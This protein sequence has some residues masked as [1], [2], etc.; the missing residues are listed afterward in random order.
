ML[1]FTPF[2]APGSPAVWQG[3]TVRILQWNADGTMLIAGQ[4]ITRRVEP[5]ELAPAEP[6]ALDG[7]IEDRRVVSR[8]R[9][10][11]SVDTLFDAYRAWTEDSGVS[12]FLIYSRHTF[13]AALQRRGFR[14]TQRH[15]GLFHR[16]RQTGFAVALDG[17]QS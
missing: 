3:N 17:V 13:G 14:P 7:W 11:V 4:R 5:Q 15:T 12:D 9:A 2:P 6:D 1:S 10:F 16:Y 8:E